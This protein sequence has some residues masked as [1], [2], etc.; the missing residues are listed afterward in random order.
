MPSMDHIQL[1]TVQLDAHGNTAP[2][3]TNT[4]ETDH[5][6]GSSHLRASVSGG[7]WHPSIEVKQLTSST[8]AHRREEGSYN[9]GIMGNDSKGAEDTAISVKVE[10]TGVLLST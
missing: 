2:V 5:P 1:F 6:S 4:R 10:Y 8:S 3:P 7:E 9:C